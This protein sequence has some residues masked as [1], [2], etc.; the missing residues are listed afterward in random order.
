MCSNKE[1][2]LKVKIINKDDFH[3]YREEILNHFN[4]LSK[5]DLY[6][7]FFRDMNKN[8]LE[9]W[10]DNVIK[11]N[12]KHILVLIYNNDELA[13]LGQISFSK[14]IGEIA[15]TV[16][17]NIRKLGLASKIFEE[18]INIAKS[19]SLI[20]SLYITFKQSNTAVCKLAKKFSFDC[21]F[22]DG[23]LYGTLDV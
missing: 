8:Q 5:S 6:L 11:N 20:N 16:N 14:S 18:C 7:R 23:E 15:L 4:T 12:D 22:V 9:D 2:N 19:T 17:P 1:N 13:S 3:F 10:I 21:S